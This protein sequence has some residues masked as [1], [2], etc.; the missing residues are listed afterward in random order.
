MDKICPFMSMRV[1][2]GANE[3]HNA[4]FGEMVNCQK[5]KCMAWG[6]WEV[7]GAYRK[8]YTKVGCTRL[9]Q[10]YASKSK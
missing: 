4:S 8:E 3:I 5:E 1:G 10:S 2:F 6:E 9:K 7:D